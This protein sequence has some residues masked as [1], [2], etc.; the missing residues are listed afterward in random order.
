MSVA[1][2]SYIALL[3]CACE[4][5]VEI[6]VPRYPTQLTANG[7]FTPDSL[8]QVELTENRYILDN[9]PFAAVPDA[10]VRIQQEGQTVAVLDYLGNTPF[11]G[12]SI[13]RATDAYPKPDAAYTLR[14]SHP[15]HGDLVASSQVPSAP[16]IVEVTLDTLDVRQEGQFVDDQIAYGFT[17]RLNDPPTENFYSLSLI[18]RFEDFGTIGINGNNMLLIENNDLLVRIQSDDPVVV[19]TYDNYRDELLFKDVSFNGQQYEMKAYGIF[20]TGDPRYFQLFDKGSPL[21]EEAYDRS[22]NIVRQAGDTAGINT[23]HAILRNT[24]EEYYDYNYTRDLQISV[25]SNP[26]AQPVQVFDNIEGGLGVFA[27]Y[28]QVEKEVTIK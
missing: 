7:L 16:Q 2:L 19:N 26:F 17:L 1:R 12:T 28:S 10:E 8:W 9:T 24:T 23:F 4:T 20:E 3:F 5:T 27:G 22:G 25:E 14:V 21:N 18:I 11:T 15:D 13:Y 6:D